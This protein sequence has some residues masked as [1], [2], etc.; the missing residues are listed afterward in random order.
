MNVPRPGTTI[1]EL[2]RKGSKSMV[3]MKFPWW[4]LALSVLVLGTWFGHG[5]AMPG[6]DP[7]RVED[8]GLFVVANSYSSNMSIPVVDGVIMNVLTAG[9]FGNYWDVQV[10]DS[11]PHSFQFEMDIGGSILLE[12]ATITHSATVYLDLGGT[13]LPGNFQLFVRWI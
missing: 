5:Q 8:K 4:T 6:P 10:L 11:Q 3:R 2:G 1:S 9:H 7:V 13:Q 12:N